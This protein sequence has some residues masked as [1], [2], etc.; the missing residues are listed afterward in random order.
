MPESPAIAI[1]PYGNALG[2]SLAGR[3]V[4]DLIWPLGC[5]DRLTG[6]KVGDLR[7]GDHLIV[8]PKTSTH[9]RVN[10]GTQAQISLLMGEPS[11]IHA[12][13]IRLLRLTHRRFFRILTFSRTLL[14]RVPNAILFPL[15]GTWV[16]D[17]STRDIH[18]SRMCSLIASAK[19]D[20]QGHKLR[21]A[22]V[23]HIRQ[24]GPEVDVMGGG[25][26]P[27]Q[28]KADGLAPYRYSVVIENMREPGYFS[29]KLVDAVLCNTVPIYWGCPN[30]SDFFD[31]A[32]I[33][34]CQSKAE[35][36]AALDKM[37][38]TD[39]DTRQPALARLRHAVSAYA[40]I[41]TR[42]ADTLRTEVEKG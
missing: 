41:E 9:F 26:K 24:N 23:D 34:Q 8:Y 10:W 39:F 27:F 2:P 38:A 11:V 5:P 14:D 33:I 17:W 19:R 1:L 40:D 32:G 18:K 25:Y 3:P 15:G 42:A 12:K 29:E 31:P 13:H 22:V 37:S 35:I 36:V 4:S 16:P 30:L 20:T 21:H 28:D 6:A 7:P